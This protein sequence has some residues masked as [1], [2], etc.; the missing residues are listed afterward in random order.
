MGLMFELFALLGGFWFIAFLLFILA[1]GV[2]ATETDSFF[3]GTGS[4]LIALLGADVFFD[5]P[6]WDTIYSNPFAIIVFLVLFGVVG[7]VYTAL[8]RWPE[9]IRSN[10]DKIN[11]QYESYK[12]KYKGTFAEYLKSNSYDFKPKY[13]SHRL[14]TWIVTWP[15]SLLWELLRKPMKYLGKGIYNMLANTFERVG[16]YTATRIHEKHIEK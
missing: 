7:A 9:F 2:Y 5:K 10:S 15:F 12:G 11:N 14:V 16:N 4:F 1:L 13:H 8:W 6:V 3:L